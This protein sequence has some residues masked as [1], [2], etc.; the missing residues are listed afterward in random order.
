MNV[1]EWLSP[2]TRGTRQCLVICVTPIRFIPAGAGNSKTAPLSVQGFAVYPR[3]RGE[4]IGN[5]YVSQIYL[6]L[7]PLARGTRIIQL[8]FILFV[9]FIPAGAGNSAGIAR[10][11]RRRPVYPRSRGELLGNYWGKPPDN[12]LSPLARGTQCRQRIVRLPLRFIPARA[13][14]SAIRPCGS[15]PMS[16]YPRS[17]GE[18]VGIY[19]EIPDGFGLSPLARGTL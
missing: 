1:P 8:V 19:P 18:L 15:T 16:V 2:L 4:L 13:G 12:G 6:G 17:R 11:I 9:R 3:W 7:S 14:N 10:L 5:V